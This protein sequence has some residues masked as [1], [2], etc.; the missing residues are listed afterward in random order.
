MA[1]IYEDVPLAKKL[2]DLLYPLVELTLFDEKGSI[3]E[4]LNAFSTLKEDQA[5]DFKNL[6]MGTPF[7]EFLQAGRNVRCLVDRLH[8]GYLRLRYDLTHFKNLQ[9]Q[10]KVLFQEGVN[11]STSSSGEVWK[12]S[13]DQTMAQYFAENKSNARA[14]T[15]RQKRELVSLLQS[16]GVDLLCGFK[17]ANF[18]CDNLQLFKDG[19]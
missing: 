7:N 10:L 8:S 13:I 12:E 18:T 9:E 17:A 4:V 6:R 2:V 1:K 5:C 15:P 14:S 16:K 3:T 19:G 11:F